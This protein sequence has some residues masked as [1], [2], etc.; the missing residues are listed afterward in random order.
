[1][2]IIN[3]NQM[4]IISLISRYFDKK[5]KNM[6]LNKLGNPTVGCPLS[7]ISNCMEAW[8]GVGGECLIILD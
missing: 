2:S 3:S 4:F 8:R 7:Q 6:D 5:K 1:M